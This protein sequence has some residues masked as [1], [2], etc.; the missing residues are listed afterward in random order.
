[1]SNE[2]L[3]YIKERN[4]ITPEGWKFLKLFLILM[5]II[6]FCG[7]IFTIMTYNQTTCMPTDVFKILLSK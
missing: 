4:K 2:I 3:N 1:M 6:V 5:G 7:L